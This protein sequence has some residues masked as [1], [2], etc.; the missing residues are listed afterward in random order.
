MKA[1]C[2]AQKSKNPSVVHGA[3]STIFVSYHLC[4]GSAIGT[5][6]GG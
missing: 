2:N 1:N 4:G 6:E 5:R 3:K